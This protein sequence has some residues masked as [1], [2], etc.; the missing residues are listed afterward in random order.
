MNRYY[1]T[2]YNW[3]SSYFATYMRIAVAAMVLILFYG[4]QKSAEAPTPEHEN[5]E[6]F[7]EEG[8]ILQNRY[9]FMY[10]EQSCQRLINRKRRI[11]HLQ[12]DTQSAY[13][14]IQVESQNYINPAEGDILSLVITYKSSNSTNKQ[15]I[16]SSMTVLKVVESK[17]WLWNQEQKTGIILSLD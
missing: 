3:I 1:K 11:I 8:L 12:T 15:T 5:F 17:V 6:E 16:T 10:D 7:T 4:C 14:R 13:M 2:A 9:K